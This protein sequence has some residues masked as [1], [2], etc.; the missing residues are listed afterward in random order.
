MGEQ[1]P[2]LKIGQDLKLKAVRLDLAAGSDRAGSSH[3][4][5]TAKWHG[6]SLMVLLSPQ[7]FERFR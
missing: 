2:S 7:P 5:K 1:A 6:H 4:K 3:R